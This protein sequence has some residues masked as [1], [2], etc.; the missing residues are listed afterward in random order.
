VDAEL[1]LLGG[2]RKQRETE[3]FIEVEPENLNAV[4]LF[5][6]VAT[7]WRYAGMGSVVGLDYTA[8]S[9]AIQMMGI[10]DSKDVFWRVRAIE[11][12]A[13]GVMQK[14]QQAAEGRNVA[15]NKA[16]PRR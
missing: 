1:A 10:A 4:E 5:F 7:Q 14:R 15:A 11:H 16:R 3:E 8:L 6:A 9:A 13:L 2:A 12:A